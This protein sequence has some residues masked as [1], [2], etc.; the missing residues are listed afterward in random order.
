MRV[1]V[2]LEAS[3]LKC[4]LSHPDTSFRFRDIVVQ[5]KRNFST[6]YYVLSVAHIGLLSRTLVVDLSQAADR[7]AGQR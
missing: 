5:S 6:V 2:N 3:P 1:I 4:F 7:C